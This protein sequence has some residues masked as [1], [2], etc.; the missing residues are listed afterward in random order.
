MHTALAPTSPTTH[1]HFPA[2]G[3]DIDIHLDCADG[4]RTR[5]MVAMARLEL[6]RLAAIFSRF[7]PQSE[8]SQLNATG[9]CACS[10]ELILVLELAL[11]AR[12]RSGG[13]FDP[14]ILPALL[15]AGYDR[16]FRDVQ[17]APRPSRPAVP[18]RGDATLDYATNTVTLQGGQLDLG[19][20]AKG[21]IVDRLATLLAEHAPVLVDAGGDIACTPRRSGAP[22]LIGIDGIDLQLE[23]DHGGIAT[24]GVDRRRWT[25]PRSGRELTHVI[26]PATGAPITSDLLRVTCCAVSCAE[27]E[28]AATSILVAGSAGAHPMACRFGAP[29]IA[30]TRDRKI[31]QEGLT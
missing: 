13:S 10:P 26:D 11:A 31:L 2:M 4:P 30:L 27:A 1:V 21:W 29:Y 9:S 16:T 7:E 5:G 23:M 12:V 6:E 15:A 24:S 25:D 3:T 22:W 28:V 14:W 20:I 17:R 19:G 8:L 18:A